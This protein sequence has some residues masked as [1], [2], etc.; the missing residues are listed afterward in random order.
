MNS[1]V[2]E[3]RENIR[4]LNS[5]YHSRKAAPAG[6]YAELERFGIEVE[7]SILVA[8]LP[9]SGSTLIGRLID[10]NGNLCHYDIDYQYSKYS[11]FEVVEPTNFKAPQHTKE[12]PWDDIVVAF[13]L[14]REVHS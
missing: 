9:D 14:Y 11:E 7:N 8:I 12:R 4:I 10:Q 1:K 3:A 13:E 2:A 5:R 6:F